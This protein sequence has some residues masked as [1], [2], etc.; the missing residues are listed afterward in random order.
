MM[1]FYK[2]FILSL[3]FHSILCF[4]ENFIRK[5]ESALFKIIFWGED[6]LKPINLYSENLLKDISMNIYSKILLKY[7]D[8]G[9]FLYKNENWEIKFSRHVTFST[10]NSHLIFYVNIH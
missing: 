10:K 1:K 2:Y 9:D 8:Y 4:N 3:L 6:L 5:N 7:K